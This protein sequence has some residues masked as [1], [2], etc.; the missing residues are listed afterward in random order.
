MFI[1]CWLCVL[2]FYIKNNLAQEKSLRTRIESNTED[3]DVIHFCICALDGRHA[4][5]KSSVEIII[6]IVYKRILNLVNFYRFPNSI[7]LRGY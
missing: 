6:R 3:V 5:I 4:G 1:Q 7:L 2:K